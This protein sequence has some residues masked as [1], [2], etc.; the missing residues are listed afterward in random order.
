G[1]NKNNSII[2]KN[3]DLFSAMVKAINMDQ[4]SY[5]SLQNELTSLQMKYREESINNIKNYLQYLE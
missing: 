4:N 5:I 1:L 3:N 2:Y